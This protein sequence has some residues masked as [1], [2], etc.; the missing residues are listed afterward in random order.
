M[1][2]ASRS[3][4]YE[5]SGGS[6]L[7]Q[8]APN[9]A[10]QQVA[11][12]ASL[13]RPI[14]FREAISALHDVVINDLRFE[15]RDK[16]AY[17]LW[18]TE[19]RKREQTIRRS[20]MSDKREA[21][22][23]GKVDKP[24]ADLK[25][26]HAEALKRYWAARKTLDRQLRK[27]NQNLW[28][29]LMPYDPV[30]TVADDVVFFECFS[31]DQSS[32]GCLTVDRGDGFGESGQ[33]QLGTTNVDYSWDLYDSFQSL[34]TYRQT[35]FQIDPTAFEV[36]TDGGGDQHREEKIELPDGWLSGFVRLQSAMA[37][38]MRKVSLPVGTM[39]SLLAFLKR[40][41]A[42]TS[43]RAV[44]F[45]LLPGRTPRL[46]LEP[47]DKAIDAHGSTYDGP[48][49][50]PI[51]IWGRRRLLTLSRLLPLADSVEVYLLGTGLPSFWVVRMGPMRLTL[52]L[53]GWT[54]NDWS[55]GSA[56]D[57]LMP[58]EKARASVVAS[59]AESLSNQRAASLDSIVK[60]VYLS[61]EVVSSALNE[62]AL[63]GQVIFDLHAGLYRWR[64]ILPLPLSD[65]EIAPPHP[66][67]QA[68][69]GLAKSGK[70]TVKDALAG[71]RGGVILT[72][73]VE[74][75]DCETLIDGDGM[76]RRGKCLCG[77]HRKSGIRNGPCRHIQALRMVHDRQQ[78]QN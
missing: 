72:G 51:R 25:T 33:T 44:R 76:I 31:V 22:A 17:Q 65:K 61:K 71:P 50:E 66:E 60:S 56:V 34:R 53:S 2:Y 78:A 35:R 15:P 23:Q 39:Y 64:S 9:L 6:K 20:A 13:N 54:T 58:Q 55:A 5:A 45:E 73:K 29:R 75:I 14:E 16:T 63:R 3:G 46:V 32:Y 18:L 30:I 1:K 41:K 26:A 4:L 68:A 21:I 8:M 67:L 38:P 59:I 49:C 42:R 36:A 28:R 62:L 40:N 19:Q 12:D 7:L 52:G 57:M 11:F 47:W 24:T 70:V 69:E 27:E 43:P 37:M 48:A 10:R 74:S 77:W